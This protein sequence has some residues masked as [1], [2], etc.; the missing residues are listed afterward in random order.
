MALTFSASTFRQPVIFNALSSVSDPIARDAFIINAQLWRDFQKGTL[1]ISGTLPVTNGGTGFSSYTVGDLL[2]ADTTTTLAKLVDVATGNALISGGVGAIPSWG[3]VSLTSAVS[4][5]LPVTNLNSGTS[6][7]ATT[8][9]RGDGTWVVPPGTGVT[10]VAETVTVATAPTDNLSVS[11]SPITTSGTLALSIS[12]W[13]M[14]KGSIDTGET[15]TI[16]TGYQVIFAGNCTN[17]GTINN[18]GTRM[19]I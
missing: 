19:V 11:G 7:G 15:L 2:Y 16:P 9:W 3:K 5:N 6:A 12:P 4:G 18:S 14:Q 10:S 1:T 13:W 17:S 8:Y